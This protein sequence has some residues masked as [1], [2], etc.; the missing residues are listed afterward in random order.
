MLWRFI[1]MTAI[2]WPMLG[3]YTLI[4]RN[5][6][7]DP[8]TVPMPSWVPF[9]PAFLPVYMSLML[10]TWLLPVA[11]ADSGR[12][13]ACV[14]ANL[15]AWFLVIPW[16]ILT[17]SMLPQPPLPEGMWAEAFRSLWNADAPYN[18]MPC[19]HATGPV[20]AAWFA[21][22]ERPTWRLPL[23]GAMVMGLPS[24]ALVWQHR[25]IDILLGI[26]AAGIGIAVADWWR[27]AEPALGKGDSFG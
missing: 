27:R 17:P 26:G 6:A 25:P 7:P 3:I 9:W 8:T 24:I 15:V 18:V 14:R 16:W 10:V 4:N 12:F 2:A 20:V 11:I 23:A 19:A 5:P 1:V 21:G 22:L 13:R